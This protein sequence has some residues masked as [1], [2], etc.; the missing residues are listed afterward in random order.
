M[1][2]INLNSTSETDFVYIG[3]AV[4]EYG[5]QASALGNPFTVEEYGREGA[6]EMY[7]RWLW[8]HIEAGD[9]DVLSALSALDEDSVLA[10]WCMP[11][12][13]HGDVVMAAWE[14]IRENRP[15]LLT[16]HFPSTNLQHPTP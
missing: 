15:G 5:L 7:R 16:P 1:R 4:S 2:L 14:W 12:A 11:E 6:V 9:G 13:C 10:C 8:E 3:R